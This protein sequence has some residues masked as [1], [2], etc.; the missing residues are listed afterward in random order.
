VYLVKRLRSVK[1]RPNVKLTPKNIEDVRELLIDFPADL[2][3]ERETGVPLHVKTVQDLRLLSTWPHG[4]HL[5][6]NQERGLMRVRI[7]CT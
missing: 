6:Y 2:K 4:L 1:R 7:E 3:I 5:I